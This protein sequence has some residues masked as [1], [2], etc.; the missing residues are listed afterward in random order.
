M[1]VDRQLPST[2]ADVRRV[3][4]DRPRQID[5]HTGGPL[6][7]VRSLET[8]IEER[9]AAADIRRELLRSV[10]GLE[11]S[12]GKRPLERVERN[13]GLDRRDHARSPAEAGLVDAFLAA[14][15]K[16]QK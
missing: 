13:A 10:E 11:E 12:F 4:A 15:R 1:A 8:R 14:A 6:I 7:G 9:Q 5:V 3:D 2:I 16:R